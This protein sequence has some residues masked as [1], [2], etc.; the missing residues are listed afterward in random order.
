MVGQGEEDRPVKWVMSAREWCD[1]SV[2]TEDGY[3]PNSKLFI[4]YKTGQQR[5]YWRENLEESL[6]R[7]AD[8]VLVNHSAW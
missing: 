5:Q 1:V 8:Y 4:E 6:P 7:Q 3:H 2:S